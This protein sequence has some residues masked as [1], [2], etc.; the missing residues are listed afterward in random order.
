[1]H[2]STGALRDTKPEVCLGLSV[3]ICRQVQLGQFRGAIALFRSENPVHTSVKV[4]FATL[5]MPE[6]V[7]LPSLHSLVVDSA[8]GP[9][10]FKRFAR[11]M[12]RI[13]VQKGN[14][15]AFHRFLFRDYHSGH[16]KSDVLAPL[17]FE[18]ERLSP[19]EWQKHYP[20]AAQQLFNLNL[21]LARS[22]KPTLS[23]DEFLDLNSI[24]LVQDPFSI[25]VQ[26]YQIYVPM[27]KDLKKQ[28]I[29]YPISI[30]QF[31]QHASFGTSSSYKMS[32]G[33]DEYATFLEAQ[34]QLHI[35]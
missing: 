3:C 14:L 24:H 8:V 15:L 27:K 30:D 32:L 29:F 6:S 7:F 18:C 4:D 13:Q 1:M 12:G 21:S 28:Q 35:Q 33:K 10:I 26:R 16:I 11:F 20:Q 19:L 2:L 23:A 34:R 25:W 5:K 9:I 31:L 22:N 17:L